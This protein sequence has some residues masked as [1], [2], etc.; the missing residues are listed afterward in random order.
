MVPVYLP[1][2]VGL[3]DKQ[4]RKDK[5]KRTLVRVRVRQNEIQLEQ[6]SKH[7]QRQLKN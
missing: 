5:K 1:G 4:R 6:R 2:A 3:L 7:F